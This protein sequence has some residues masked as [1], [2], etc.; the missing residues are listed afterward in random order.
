M[1]GQ[2]ERMPTAEMLRNIEREWSVLLEEIAKVPA[3]RAAEPGVTGEW[4]VKDLLG[5]V[6]F[7]D[8]QVLEDIARDR[9]GLPPLQNDWQ[10]MND[11]SFAERKELSYERQLRDFDDSHRAVIEALSAIDE[12]DPQIVGV[13][14]WEHYTEHAAEIRAWRERNGF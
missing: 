10:A 9:Q 8:D 1:S 11:R 7:W 6:A 12:I 5:H 14:T 13:D 4:S 2:S 3:D